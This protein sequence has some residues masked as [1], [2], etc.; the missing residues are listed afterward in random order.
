[1]KA[2]KTLWRGKG[3]TIVFMVFT[4][5]FMFSHQSYSAILINDVD[6]IPSQPLDIEVITF[7]IY[8]E[9]GH[10][11][12]WVEYDQFTQVETFLRLDMYVDTGHFAA[13]SEWTYS[14]DISP[15]SAD[16]Y[17]LEVRAFDYQLD[18]LQDTYTVDFTVVP[19]PATVLLL[20][21]GG[22]LLRK[23]RK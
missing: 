14:K 23:H 6:V 9:A 1:M 7:E 15:L 17:T 22:L 4:V 13:I 18:T 10:T 19:E 5:L 20:G 21:F 8:G 11:P 12:S 16:T 3:T 2:Q